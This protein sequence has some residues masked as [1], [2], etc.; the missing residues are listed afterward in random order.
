MLG[1]HV[2]IERDQAAVD[3]GWDPLRFAY[4]PREMVKAKDCNQSNRIVAPPEGGGMALLPHHNTEGTRTI[5]RREVH[6]EVKGR[7]CTEDW[8]LAR[9]PEEVTSR[10]WELSEPSPPSLSARTSMM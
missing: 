4:R 5:S 10:T 6:V 7:K 1:S 9:T 3:V 8:F 2:Q